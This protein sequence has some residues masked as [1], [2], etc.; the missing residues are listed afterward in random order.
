[1]TRV[2]NEDDEDNKEVEV[3]QAESQVGTKLSGHTTRKVIILVL[4]M[5]LVQPLQDIL[6]YMDMPDSFS[7]GLVLVYKLG[8]GTTKNGEL[9]FK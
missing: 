4:I 6:T 2:M 8:G 5:L 7:H 9:Q 1:M 3:E